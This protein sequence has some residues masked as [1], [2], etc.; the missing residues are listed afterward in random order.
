MSSDIQTIAL[1]IGHRVDAVRADE[2]R[3]GVFSMGERIAVALVLDR[4]DL[5]PKGYTMLEAIERLGPDW[6]RAARLVQQ[7]YGG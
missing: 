6:T 5:L 3:I 2:G 4:R 1:E 7:A